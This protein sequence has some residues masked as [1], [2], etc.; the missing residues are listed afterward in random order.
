ML[1]TRFTT[2]N[3]IICIQPESG[4]HYPIFKR[5]ANLTT[6]CRRPFTIFIV[7]LE[8]FGNLPLPTRGS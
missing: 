6:I 4:K 5:G 3:E 2:Y 1:D 7:T 8:E